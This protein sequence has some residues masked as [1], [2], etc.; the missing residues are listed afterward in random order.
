[1][2]PSQ[3]VNCGEAEVRH[4]T[5]MLQHD[6]YTL[7]CRFTDAEMRFSTSNRVIC[8]F[9]PTSIINCVSLQTRKLMETLSNKRL[10]AGARGLLQQ[11]RCLLGKCEVTSP[12]PA[13]KKKKRLQAVRSSA[14]FMVLGPKALHQQNC[15]SFQ[16]RTIYYCL[17]CGNIL[18]AHFN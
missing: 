18:Q 5:W 14:F 10:Q 11:C 13:P 17:T 15:M 8:N 9:I 12:I 7:G 4:C 1:M 6:S 16:S 2:L 3:V